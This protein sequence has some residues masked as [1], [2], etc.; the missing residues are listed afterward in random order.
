[1]LGKGPRTRLGWS[2]AE[3]RAN[4]LR[5][6]VASL[7]NNHCVPRTDIFDTNLVLVMQSCHRYGRP[8][9]KDRFKHRIRG[10]SA[11]ASDRHPNVEKRG[12]SLFWRELECNCPARRP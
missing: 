3:Y 8:I 6:D 10:C 9:D 4:D 1:M 12:Q 5:D 2:F 11:S 7:T